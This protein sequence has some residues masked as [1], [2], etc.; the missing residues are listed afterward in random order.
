MLPCAPLKKRKLAR[1]SGADPALLANAL[2]G[3]YAA[4][5]HPAIR[6]F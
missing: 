2:A 6:T 1:R 3:F 5:V 4:L